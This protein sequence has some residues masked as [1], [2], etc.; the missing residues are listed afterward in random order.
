MNVAIFTEVLSPHISGISTYAQVLKKGLEGRG[1]KVLI[2][3]SSVHTE[4]ASVRRGVIRC[5]ARKCRNKY[6]YECRNINDVHVVKFLERFR[7]DIIHILTD[8]KIG[9][10]GISIADRLRCPVVF[11]VLDN[12]ADRFAN[13]H[14]ILWRIKTFFERRHFCDMIDNAQAVT[15]TNKRAA[16]FLR[17]AGRKRKVLLTPVATDKKR[18]N[19]NNSNYSAVIKMRKK[20]CIPKNATVAVFAGDLSLAKRLDHIIN[21]FKRRLKYEDNI[22]FLIVGDGTET[23]YLKKLCV[24]YHLLD[25]IHF[26]GTLANSIMPEVFSACDIYISAAEDGLMSMSFAEAMACGLP[27]MVKEDEEKYVYSMIRDGV[28]GFAYKNEK[29]FV[30]YLKQLSYFDREKREKMKYIVRHSLKGLNC[31]YM[32]KCMEKVYA[33]AQKAFNDHVTIEK[34]I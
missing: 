23:A 8:T 25:R 1:H 19:Y 32:A 9:Y 30:R 22:H 13:R 7:P 14:P 15:S 10:M 16:V 31:I 4:Q 11:S 6:G 28:N 3:T 12:Y 24:R 18:F 20:L 2:V 5:P 26:A 33:N 29:E 21:T 17:S 34:G 27:V